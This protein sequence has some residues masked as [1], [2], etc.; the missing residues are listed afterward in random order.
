M[1][2]IDN[3]PT[4][5]VGHET[6]KWTWMWDWCCRRCKTYGGVKCHVTGGGQDGNTGIPQPVESDEEI[7]KRIWNAHREMTKGQCAGRE[8]EVG[9]MWRVHRALGRATM[10]ILARK[11]D[12]PEGIT[13]YAWP[14]WV[15]G[16]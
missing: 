5:L 2:D 15:K 9:R 8:F 4:R 16:S 3:L 11:D 6:H 7:R 10:V 13:E 14:P 1:S 12:P